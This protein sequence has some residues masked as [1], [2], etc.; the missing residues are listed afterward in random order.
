MA[1]GKDKR[2][3]ELEDKAT[4]LEKMLTEVLAENKD[5]K[6]RLGMNSANSS[7]PPS[8]DKPGSKTDAAEK[9]GAKKKKR[10]A[11]NGH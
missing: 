2:I 9:S 3:K 8:S 1:I 10:G 5:L 11:Q 6:R 7:M 4:Y